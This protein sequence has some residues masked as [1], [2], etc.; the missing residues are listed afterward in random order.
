MEKGKIWRAAEDVESLPESAG[1]SSITCQITNK[2]GEMLGRA[3]KR[4][5]LESR[6]MKSRWLIRGW[7]DIPQD[8]G[9]AYCYLSHRSA[10]CSPQPKFDSLGIPCRSGI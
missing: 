9:L 1:C 8:L 3:H 7:Q 10:F 5:D 4:R 2:A 6:D